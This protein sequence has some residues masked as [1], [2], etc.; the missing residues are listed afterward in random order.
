MDVLG[1]ARRLAGRG[2]CESRALVDIARTGI[3][4]PSSG[5]HGVTMLRALEAYGPA[6]AAISVAAAAHGDRCALVDERGPLSFNELDRRSNAVANAL[7]ARGL[8]GGDIVGVLCRNHR[9]LLDSIFGTGKLGART[10][11]LNTDFSAPQ[12]REVCEREGVQLLIHDEEFTAIV[13]RSGPPAG[14]VLAWHEE[15]DEQTLDDLIEQGEESTPPKPEKK[16][17]IVLL[18]SGTTGAPRGASREVGISLAVPG[19]LLSKIPFRSRRT[20]LVAS[21]IFHAWGLGSA[22]AAIG[23]GCTVVTHRRFDARVVLDAMQAHRLDT[24]ITIPILLRR[25]LALG[26]EEIRHRDLRSLRI[27][28]LSGSALPA[29]LATQAMDAFGDVVYNLYGS[30]EV[31][32]ISIATPADMRAAPGCVGKPPYGTTVRLFDENDSEVAPGTTGRIFVANGAQF[33]GY[34]GGGHKQVIDGLMSSGDVGHFDRDGYLFVD[35]RDD[36]MI[37]SGGE[38]V[39]PGEIEELLAG[40]DAIS[41]AALVG[42]PDPDFGQRLRAYVVR[43]GSGAIDED[44]VTAYVKASLARYKVPREVIFL[45]ELPRN[46]AGKVVKRELPDC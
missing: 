39:F 14:R 34:T 40:H 9:G 18:T 12:L 31:A 15:S 17:R 32:Y 45:A 29:G 1:E 21:P 42:V 26:G 2:L 41:E 44:G 27:I 46:P 35:G 25:L 6:G 37:V 24:L 19:G 8:R 11:L 28:A 7:R 16:G 30:T 10:L 43:S 3:L 22:L 38:N 33:E 20:V 13:E 23:L 36:D 4:R 5:L